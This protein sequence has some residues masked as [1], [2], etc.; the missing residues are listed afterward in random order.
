MRS[1]QPPI[2][3]FPGVK[4][5]GRGIDNPPPS[6]ADVKERVELYLCPILW[7]VVA[8]LRVNFTFTF[9]Y[10]YCEQKRTLPWCFLDNSET[11]LAPPEYV[12]EICTFNGVIMYCDMAVN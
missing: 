3:S 8:G 11:T 9:I 2:L 6:S 12:L 5:L 4:R 1:T 10:Q 7:A